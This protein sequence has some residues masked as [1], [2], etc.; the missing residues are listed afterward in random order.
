MIFE[1][2]DLLCLHFKLKSKELEGELN[3]ILNTK[4]EEQQILSVRLSQEQT[5]TSSKEFS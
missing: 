5:L 4:E 2:N 3:L 1:G